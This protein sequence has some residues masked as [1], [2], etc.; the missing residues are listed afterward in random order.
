M[1]QKVELKWKKEKNPNDS[2]EGILLFHRNSGAQFIF[3]FSW[4]LVPSVFAFYSSFLS[5]ME[6]DILIKAVLPV[7]RQNV[8][9]F[10]LR[11][12]INV[13][14]Q[15]EKKINSSWVSY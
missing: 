14:K 9:S 11:F 3:V 13:S 8:A 12:S 7:R 4:G 5:A 6:M 2:M 15:K 1:T 10:N